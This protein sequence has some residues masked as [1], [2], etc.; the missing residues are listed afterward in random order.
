MLSD[1]LTKSEEQEVLALMESNDFEQLLD[2]V[3]DEQGI[4]LSAQ[5][6]AVHS[7]LVESKLKKFYELVDA[8]NNAVH[9]Q[10]AS[11]RIRRVLYWSAAAVF[12]LIICSVCYK[13][14]NTNKV[15]ETIVA[16]SSLAKPVIDTVSNKKNIVSKTTSAKPGF[17]IVRSQNELRKKVLLED[18]SVV[19]LGANSSLKF[20]SKFEASH[21]DV[22]LE[23]EAFFEIA[24][25]PKRPFTVQSGKVYTRVLGTSFKINAFKKDVEVSVATGSVSVNYLGKNNVWSNLAVMKPGDR[26]L[27]HNQNAK[28]SKI[29]IGQILSWKSGHMFFHKESLKY[30]LATYCQNYNLDVRFM[31]GAFENEKMTIELE[32]NAPLSK[33]LSILSASAGF[34]YSIDS[35]KGHPSRITIK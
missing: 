32:E 24:K 33:V 25:N 23:G 3:L 6:D 5:D 2:L 35:I 16:T 9:T 34:E 14:N 30:I 12:L 21:R 22:S 28:L 20:P 7:L 27:W 10:K 13:Y 15:P 31:N 1:K 17:R 26:I 11:A 4:E 29:D 19:T 8:E 18:G